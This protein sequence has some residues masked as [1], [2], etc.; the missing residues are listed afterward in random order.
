MHIYLHTHI[1]MYINIYIHIRKQ[2][3]NERQDGRRI[4]R[5]HHDISQH[6][7]VYKGQNGIMRKELKNT[8][9][10]TACTLRKIIVIL[11]DIGES[12]IKSISVLE[13]AVT[14]MRTQYECE[15]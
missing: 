13:T 5:G 6:N 15:R 12:K 1:Y 7:S 9:S 4:V 11:N 2:T 3:S 8:I 10:E 14:K